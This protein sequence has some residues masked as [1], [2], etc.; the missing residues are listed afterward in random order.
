MLQS[1]GAR[2]MDKFNKISVLETPSGSAKN[3]VG[4]REGSWESAGHWW[5]QDIPYE[6]REAE[7][8][9]RDRE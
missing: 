3:Q 9:R 1:P 4:K 2:T 8:C 7:S 6:R 5:V